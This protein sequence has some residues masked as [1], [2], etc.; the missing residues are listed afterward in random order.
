M[1][2]FACFKTKASKTK[3]KIQ[4]EEETNEDKFITEDDDDEKVLK[5][6]ESLDSDLDKNDLS[7][8]KQTKS[9]DETEIEPGE[10]VPIKKRTKYQESPKNNRLLELSRAAS[11]IE[12]SN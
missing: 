2:K 3:E 10:V 1:V 6:D 7:K 9:D 8:R 11:L 12:D 5:I 4:Q